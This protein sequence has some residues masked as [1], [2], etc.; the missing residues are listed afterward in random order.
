MT[1]KGYEVNQANKK[2]QRGTT[3]SK[4][5][6]REFVRGMEIRMGSGVEK[7]AEL[8]SKSQKDKYAIL[9]SYFFKYLTDNE[10][11]D[12][13]NKQE[14]SPIVTLWKRYD[15][16]FIYTW[17]CSQERAKEV[18]EKD[19]LPLAEWFVKNCHNILEKI[20]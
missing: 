11:F 19:F 15:G 10:A 12:E 6:M 14:N 2:R 20:E 16:E 3:I 13:L 18:I 4:K 8:Y 9:A 5:A 1:K 17:N 7:S